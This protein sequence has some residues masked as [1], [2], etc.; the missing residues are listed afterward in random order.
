VY[1]FDTLDTLKQ[2]ITLHKEGDEHYLPQYLFIGIRQEDGT[3]APLEYT[4]YPIGV[5]DADRA[6]YLPSPLE[7]MAAPVKEFVVRGGGKPSLVLNPRG[8]TMIED[9]F[10]ESIPELIVFPFHRII[11]LYKGASPIGESEWYQRFYPYYPAISGKSLKASAEDKAF[12]KVFMG[13]LTKRKGYLRK[14]NR[15]LGG[16]SPLAE[17]E[18]TGVNQLRLRIQVADAEFDDCET[19]FYQTKVHKLVPYMRIV[20]REGTPITK[21]LVSGV[22]PIPDMDNPEVISQWAKE[23]TPT[24]G[25]DFIMLKYVHR[26][27]IGTA[28]PIYGTVRIFHDGTS[29]ITIQSPKAVRKLD[30]S[31]DFRDLDALLTR[32]VKGFPLD[33]DHIELGE[34]AMIFQLNS[35]RGSTKFT[36]KILKERLKFFSPFFQEITGLKDTLLSIRYKAV[37]QYASENSIFAFLTQYTEAKKL[38]GLAP[39]MDILVKLQEEFQMSKADAEK[40]IEE[41]LRRGSTLSVVVPEENEFMESF[42]P[43]IDIHIYG[44]SPTYTFHVHRIDSYRTLQRLYSMLCALFSDD[45]EKLFTESETAGAGAIYAAEEA[46]VEER[47]LRAEK[48]RHRDTEAE[49]EAKASATGIAAAEDD[50]DEEDFLESMRPT[51]AGLKEAPVAGLKEEA[52]AVGK[53]KAKA[54]EPL[55]RREET[56]DVEPSKWYLEQLKR[57]DPTI[58]DYK[59]TV[60]NTTY[61][62]KCQARDERMPA[63]LTEAQYNDMIE[64]YEPEIADGTLFFNLYP[65]RKEKDKI[66]GQNGIKLG[67]ASTEITVTRYGSV[68]GK[69]NYLFCPELFCLYD[70][71][72]ILQKDFDAKV[73]REG[74]PKP[75][76]TCPFCKGREIPLPHDKLV[77]GATVFRRKIKPKSNPAKPHL[78][79]GFYGKLKDTTNPDG[80]AVPCCF[81]LKQTLRISDP[82]YEHLES[83]KVSSDKGLLL[84]VVDADEEPVKKSKAPKKVVAAVE[85]EESID[86]VYALEFNKLD[87]TYI[88]EE[89]KQQLNPGQPAI[90]PEPF[91]IYFQQDSANFISRAGGSRQL[92]KDKSQGFIRIGTQM[93]PI[94]TKCDSKPRATES[95]LGVLAPLLYVNSIADVRKLLLKTLQGPAGVRLFVNANFGNLVNEFYVPSDPDL[96]VERDPDNMTDKPDVGITNS[97]QLWAAGNLG[98]TVTDKNHYAVRRIHKSYNR[99]IAFLKDPTQRKDMRHLSTFLTE[100]G[101]LPDNDN[102]LQVVVLEWSPGDASVIVRCSPY[103]FSLERHVGNDFAFVTRDAGG[104]YQLILYTKNVPA[105]RGMGAEHTTIHRW[106]EADKNSDEPWPRIVRDR[107]NEYMSKCKSQYTSVFTSQKDIDS[108]SLVP[109]SVALTTTLSIAYKDGRTKPVKPYGIVRDSYNHAIFVVYSQSLKSSG[110]MIPMPIVDDGFMPVEEQ[111]YLDIGDVKYASADVV[112]DYYKNYLTR[113]FASYPG[114]TV[115]NIIK[116]KKKPVE[117]LRLENG[118]YIPTSDIAPGKDM[119][120]YKEKSRKVDEWYINRRLSQSCGT[121]PTIVDIGRSRLEELYQTFRYMVASWI[122]SEESGPDIRENI[123]KIVFHRRLPDYEKRKR[124]EILCGNWG[125]DED[126]GWLALMKPSE[127][128]LNSPMGLLRQDCRVLDEGS[129]SGACVWKPEEGT[130]ALHVEEDTEIRSTEPTRVNTRIMFSRRVIDELIRFPKRRLE[131]LE[132]AVSKMSTIVE[133]IREGDQYIIP[134]RGMNWVSLLRLDWRPPE[135]EVPLFYEEMASGETQETEEGMVA[136]LPKAV[137]ELVGSKTP[138]KLWKS[139]KGAASIAGILRVSLDT[140]GVNAADTII[141]DEGIQAYVSTSKA[142]LPVGIMDLTKGVPEIRFIKHTEDTEA[143]TSALVLVFLKG[144]IGLLIERNNK[145]TVKIANLDGPLADAWTSEEAVTIPPVAPV[146]PV[147]PV[148]PVTPVAPVAPVAPVKPVAPVPP[149]APVTP[150]EPVAPVTPAP[151][152]PVKP[153]EPV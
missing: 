122:A 39:T 66:K 104:L 99:F 124:L 85:A 1:P 72:M 136:A 40:N 6:I 135:R 59:A 47:S 55:L 16:E 78:Y 151:V 50:D 131:L 113:A 90:L 110:P 48:S 82:E 129:C 117:G 54:K 142:H 26:P 127:E 132:N 94:I 74:K 109:L 56:A 100:P 69:P 65:L 101:L 91:D 15:F 5:Q 24:I 153:V 83:L 140:L 7:A 25:H 152:A 42:N 95:L 145:P 9:V 32:V 10:K 77:K 4:W 81:G 143:P 97:L 144:E 106:R 38:E 137:D 68:P 92:L 51:A 61:A 121:D 128:A 150:V 3:Y 87:K 88:V 84:D 2:S 108:S 105:S 29:D 23:P 62:R 35:T 58:F 13:Y 149:V 70:K 126:D 37:S 12:A 36:K 33:L 41:W 107:I 49:E 89:N 14:I 118:V 115:K 98:L 64:E 111:L 93:G 34:A 75:P 133:P 30:P 19:L 73:D 141:G 102:G 45:P 96:G 71:K 67:E 18:I 114:Y 130:C 147:L 27:A 44:P 123:E 17:L 112:A 120:M 22:L 52:V 76:G 116:N 80:F 148:A 63:V 28:C 79:I 125:S 11:S 57:A 20:P 46:A 103:G 8:R 60:P 53:S 134:E 139:L 119:S 21:V 31:T 86:V 138:Y 43:G 146:A